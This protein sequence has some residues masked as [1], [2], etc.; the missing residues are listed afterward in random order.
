[1]SEVRGGDYGRD[2]GGMVADA[3]SGK[4]GTRGTLWHLRSAAADDVQTEFRDSRP[5]HLSHAAF[6]EW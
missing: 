1:M 4:S 2:V 3:S 5:P 6:A